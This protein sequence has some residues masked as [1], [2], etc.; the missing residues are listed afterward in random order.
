[1]KQLQL[2]NGVRALLVPLS[3]LK[4]VTVE[5]FIKIGSKYEKPGE[6]GISHF[7]EHMAFKGTGKRPTARSIVNEIDSK[8]AAYNAGTG[9]EYTS[10][11]IKTVKENVP[12][13]LELLADILFD[14]KLEDAEIKKERGV[15]TEEIKMYKDNPL[16]GLSGE[17]VKFLYGESKIGCWNVSGEEKDV[18]GI[19][20]K[21]LIDYRSKYLI[22][23]DI[24]VVM[25]GDIDLNKSEEFVK[26]Y[27][28]FFVNASSARLP[29]VEMHLTDKFRIKREQ[30]TEQGH[31]CVG[32]PTISWRDERRYAL[33]LLEIILG[34]YSSSRLQQKIRED[35]GLAYYIYSISD[36]FEEGG[37]MAFQAGVK[38]EALEKA[39]EMTMEEMTFTK[40]K[41]T[42]EELM[43]AKDYLTGRIK[44]QM[45]QS[46]FWSDFLGQKLLLE[47]KT[48]T[49]EE[50]LL[51]YQSVKIEEVYKLADEF[52]TKEKIKSISVFGN[53]NKRLS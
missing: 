52:L 20:R 35:E 30:E 48:T 6:F 50:E 10:Y 18:A 3:G 13:A 1:M 9:H 41:V 26:K 11:Y 14:S 23:N 34:G 53:T 40:Q 12:W 7:L 16:M 33:K 19:D 32:V 44:L 2:G 46:D 43:R 49:P 21:A 39:M 22:P 28:S 15:I 31:F 42:D 5:V 38:I 37:Y 47:G 27:F 17:F 45:D 29:T 36:N 4:S 51:K 25:S 24:L 8:G